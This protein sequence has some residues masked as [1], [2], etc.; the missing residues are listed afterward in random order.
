VTSVEATKDG[1][2]ES[3]GAGED[4]TCGT[5]TIDPSANVTQN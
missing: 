5:V 4:G 3:I 1:S 2:A